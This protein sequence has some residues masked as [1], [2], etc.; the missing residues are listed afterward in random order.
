[1]AQVPV[2]EVWRVG[3]KLSAK[4]SDMGIKTALALADS[5]LATLKKRFSVVLER[6]ARE[7]NGIACLPWENVPSP[8]QQ[9][10]CSRSFGQPVRG[11]ADLEEA[12]VNYAAR[13]AEKLRVGEQY[14]GELMVF[15]RTNPFKAQSPQYSKSA[16]IRFLT[17]TR[18][19]RVIAQ[20]AVS[21]LRS[22][23][24]KNF[25]YAKAGVMLSDLVDA[26]GLQ[27][28]LFGEDGRATVGEG[29]SERLMAVM[30]EI[31]RKSRATVCM[32]RQT[33]TG[34]YAMLRQYLSPGYTTDWSQLPTVE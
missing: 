28:D 20:Q 30:D 21:L 5:D 31:N 15:V 17:A 25:D 26:T 9:I 14:A 29:R 12:V 19:S 18:D 33:G 27:E 13:V 1:V 11:L 8:K 10:M 24:R 34:R 16:S 22:L 6:T 7:L 2:D 3:R 4:L 23:Y 32:A